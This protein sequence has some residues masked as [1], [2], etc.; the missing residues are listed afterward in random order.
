[1][2]VTVEFPQLSDDELTRILIPPTTDK[3]RLRVV[4]DT[5]FNNEVDDYF[6]LAWLLL[7]QLSPSGELNKIDL[8]AVYVAPYSFKARLDKLIKAY[9]IYLM[10]LNARTEQ[11]KAFLSGYETRIKSIDALGITPCQLEENPHLNGSNEGGIDGS[12]CSI[13]DLCQKM[14]FDTTNKVFKGATHFMPSPS[15]GVESDAAKHL[16]ELASTA[17]PEEPLYVIAIGAPTN[18]ASALL[19]KPEILP[20]IVVI[21]DAGYPTN[22]HHLVNHSL[23]LEQDLYASQLLFSSGVPLVY[24]PGFYIAQQLSMSLSDVKDWFQ[25]SGEVGNLL[26]DRYIHN[27]LF[28][29]YGIPTPKSLSDPC[30]LGRSWVIWD[31]ANVAWLLN[32]SSVPSSL[33]KSPILTNEKKWQANPNGHWIREAHQI[34]V[35]AIF[36]QFVKQLRDWSSNGGTA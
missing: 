28:D 24:I 1:M 4:I 19:M 11:Q 32:P 26:C 9:E 23:N 20:N 25:E 22:V 10:P 8:E 3:N 7:Q 30:W 18:V 14:G 12:Y 27:P 36:P 5:D 16:V 2:S 33:V 34:S 21:W 17:S 31:I 6:A 29:F 13:L 35:N 15:E